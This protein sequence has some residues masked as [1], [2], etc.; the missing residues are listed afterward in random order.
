M[1][2]N[3]KEERSTKYIEGKLLD[4][5][6]ENSCIINHNEDLKEKLENSE[7]DIKPQ[8]ELIK[9]FKND[10]IQLENKL[11]KI[12]NKTLKTQGMK[13]QC[14]TQINAQKTMLMKENNI[15]KIPYRHPNHV[16]RY[17]RK[18]ELPK[19]N[20]TNVI[21]TAGDKSI[22]NPNNQQQ[23]NLVWIDPLTY[24]KLCSTLRSSYRHVSSAMASQGTMQ[25]HNKAL[26]TKPL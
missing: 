4:K 6:E 11:E 18:S 13:I 12:H 24:Q 19:D 17:T 8:V 25:P 7:D 2:N 21:K 10:N 1:K 22:R 16:N 3:R 14:P 20:G 23:I 15:V 9:K 26:R 5:Q